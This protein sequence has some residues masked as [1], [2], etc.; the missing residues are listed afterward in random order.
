[1]LNIF[2]FRFQWRCRT[3]K[4][5]FCFDSTV[6]VKYSFSDIGRMLA[7]KCFSHKVAQART[8]G[9]R[10]YGSHNKLRSLLWLCSGFKNVPDI[11][12]ALLVYLLCNNYSYSASR[13]REPG[14]KK[15]TRISILTLSEVLISFE[16]VWTY[17]ICLHGSQG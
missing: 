7:S 17:I 13:H 10:W 16:K 1:M 15:Y 6:S 2:K 9:W 12:L 3:F 11:F 5:I 8:R 14:P 4:I